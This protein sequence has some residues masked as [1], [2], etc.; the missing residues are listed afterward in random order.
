MLSR[1]KHS[2][3][4]GRV[5]EIR[6]GDIRF[7]T[8]TRAINHV[9]L[10]DFRRLPKY[11]SCKRVS[12]LVVP[13]C[14]VQETVLDLH[15]DTLSRVANDNGYF[16]T[17][18]SF[19]RTNSAKGNG[20][21][22]LCIPQLRGQQK[23]ITPKE[24]DMLTLLQADAGRLDMIAVPDPNRQQF[25]SKPLKKAI[26]QARNLLDGIG[27]DATNIL[28]VL[29][30][31]TEPTAL[32]RRISYLLDAGHE[33]IA[34]RYR[35]NIPSAYAVSDVLADE[36]IWIHLSGIHK[37]HGNRIP[38]VSQLH[39]MPFFSFDT[40]SSYKYPQGA[41]SRKKQK[42]DP[43]PKVKGGPDP[44]KGPKSHKQL[45]AEMEAQRRQ[46][47]NKVTRFDSRALGYLT[48][49]S[50]IEL[51]GHGLNCDC[52]LCAEKSIDTFFQ[53]YAL[54]DGRFSKSKFRVH[55]RIHELFASHS[56]FKNAQHEITADAFTDYLQRKPLVKHLNTGIQ[57]LE[58]QTT[59]I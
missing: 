16:N 34:F 4:R 15:P 46:K 49:K 33:A 18:R 26:N 56:E 53:N 45:V 51:L 24:I 10:R 20:R 2:S 29:D 57:E 28:P 23:P 17:K 52:F 44:A 35:P 41:R 43:F 37:T 13:P 31:K 54:K 40:L 32:K 47:M 58:G 36:D 11:N 7:S 39:L 6:L 50:H 3:A 9:E 21:I 38:N 30:L 25:Y 19:I 48:W 42:Q 22:K 5:T 1:L 27:K 14:E 12:D 8:P 59:L 55:T